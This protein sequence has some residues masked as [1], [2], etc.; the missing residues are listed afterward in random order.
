MASATVV[1]ATCFRSFLS[2]KVVRL[3]LKSG[4]EGGLA[5]QVLQLQCAVPPV[6]VVA[7]KKEANVSL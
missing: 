5:P 3:A 4:G 2:S 6:V 7:C 1:V